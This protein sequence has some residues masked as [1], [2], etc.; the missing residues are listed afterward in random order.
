LFKL[1]FLLLSAT[2]LRAIVE[3]VGARLGITSAPPPASQRKEDGNSRPASEP[4]QARL[5]SGCTDLKRASMKFK[6][7]SES[8]GLSTVRQRTQVLPPIGIKSE[9]T[10]D[11]RTSQRQCNKAEGSSNFTAFTR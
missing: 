10:S 8:E 6:P 4:P 3:T 2:I 9:K 7:G 5:I 11:D 1:H